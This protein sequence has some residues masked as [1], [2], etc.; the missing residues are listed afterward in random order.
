[1][2]KLDETVQGG[3]YLVGGL[4][5]DANG[6]AVAAPSEQPSTATDPL[7]KWPQLAAAGYGSVDAVSAATDEQL[8]AIDG[9]GEATLTKI[10]ELAPKK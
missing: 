2:P 5:V 10:R 3:R 4:W 8:L 9:I 1:M 6:N 7:A